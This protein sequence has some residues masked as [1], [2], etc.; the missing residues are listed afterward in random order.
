MTKEK[1]ERTLPFECEIFDKEPQEV[2]NIFG[3]GIMHNPTRCGCCL[4]Y[5]YG[6]AGYA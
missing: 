4:R 1:K 2:K 5:H 6:Y 3:G